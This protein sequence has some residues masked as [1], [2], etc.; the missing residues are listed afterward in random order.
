MFG[1]KEFYKEPLRCVDI[2]TGETKWSQEGF[3]QGGLCLVGDTLVIQGEAG[4]IVLVEPTPKGYHELAKTQPI[5]KKCW[6][7]AVVSDGKLFARSSSE[8]VCLD[9]SGK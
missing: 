3:G 4:Q 8:A 2:R 6:N 1:F 7:M 5:G 9:V